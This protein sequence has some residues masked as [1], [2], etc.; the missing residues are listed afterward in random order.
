[1][2]HN[3]NAHLYHFWKNKHATNPLADSIPATRPTI[4]I[5]N[6]AEYALTKTSVK[7]YLLLIMVLPVLLLRTVNN[8]VGCVSNDVW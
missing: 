5:S 3:H 8:Q 2:M 4:L 7:D 6:T 1:M